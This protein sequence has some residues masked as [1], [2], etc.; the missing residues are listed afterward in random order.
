MFFD[1]LERSWCVLNLHKFSGSK[2]FVFLGF[3]LPKFYCFSAKFRFP[4]MHQLMISCI[5]LIFTHASFI[6][7]HPYL[8]QQVTATVFCFFLWQTHPLLS[9]TVLKYWKQEE[10]KFQDYLQL[11]STLY[12]GTLCFSPSPSPLFW[13]FKT[14]HREVNSLT[15]DFPCLSRFWFFSF[16]GS[17]WVNES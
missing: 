15:L 9:P 5:W 13:E 6:Y 2:E 12:G 16:G 4:E 17:K 11:A 1:S 14:E 3:T 8:D 7:T 10:G